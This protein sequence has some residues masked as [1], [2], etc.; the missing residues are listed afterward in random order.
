MTTA[1]LTGASR[2]IGRATALALARRG[3]ALSLLGRPSE[4]LARAVA[5]LREAGTSVATF[6]CDLASAEAVQSA[7]K[8]A[9]EASGTPDCVLN[10]AGVA[11]RRQVRDL[12]PQSFDRQLAV[13]LRAPFLI[14]RAV[15]PGMLA[16]RTGRI[17]HVASIS[18]T[19][20]TAG[21]SAY[22]ASKWAL[23]GFMKSLAEE[24]RDTGLMTV[25]LLPGSVA[26]DMLCDS[27]FPA[28]MGPQD[29][30]R[31][32]VYYALE[33][34]LAHNGGVIEMFGV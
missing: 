17:V 33:A 1:L 32:L 5:E 27:G 10:I 16:R 7:M 19:L 13:N 12:D 24:L 15:L 6:P 23:V 3:V 14:T 25:A 4:G 34:P 31:S 18:S 20:G 2:G 29:V 11:E 8:A 28:R 22:N 9:L 21:Q 30:A 26:T